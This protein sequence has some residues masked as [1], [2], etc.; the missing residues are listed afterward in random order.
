MSQQR[1]PL[2]GR[3]E[4]YFYSNKENLLEIHIIFLYILHSIWKDSLMLISN[5]K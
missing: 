3:T 1:H 2:F 5:V 4:S